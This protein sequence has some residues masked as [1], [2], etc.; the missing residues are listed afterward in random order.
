MLLA[1]RP[2]SARIC[3]GS[4][5]DVD[6]RIAYAWARAANT[7]PTSLE[8]LDYERPDPVALLQSRFDGHRVMNATVKP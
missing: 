6:L 5:P 8:T 1:R 3:D 2:F 4:L 7:S